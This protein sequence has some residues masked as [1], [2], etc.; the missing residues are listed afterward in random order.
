MRSWLSCTTVVRAV[1]GERTS[2]SS[3]LRS[4]GTAKRC[5]NARRI[6][7]PA[8]QI[9]GCQ[10]DF[11]TARLLDLSR[12]LQVH[13]TM[14]IHK[15]EVCAAS[16]ALSVLPSPLNNTAYIQV[17]GLAAAPREGNELNSP[18]P[19]TRPTPDF[20]RHRD[21]LCVGPLLWTCESLLR[22]V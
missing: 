12:T 10:M 2:D 7:S 6:Y 22:G 13:Y 17:M 16:N 14:G 18:Q 4:S 3:V 21:W 19:Y 5:C 20:S 9:E 11:L 15:C 8:D 1:L